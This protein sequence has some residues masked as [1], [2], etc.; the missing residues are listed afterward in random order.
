MRGNIAKDSAVIR[1]NRERKFMKIWKEI[2]KH[3][4]MVDC[5]KW[6]PLEEIV[7][8]LSSN[9]NIECVLHFLLAVVD[10]LELPINK[11]EIQLEKVNLTLN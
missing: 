11:N 3:I 5:E 9:S 2:I 8:G 7:E 1:C 6:L 4:I 10:G